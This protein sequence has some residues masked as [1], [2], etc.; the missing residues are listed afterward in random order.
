MTFSDAF[1]PVPILASPFDLHRFKNITYMKNLEE[2]MFG[3]LARQEITLGK[4]FFFFVCVCVI[5]G[6]D[7]FMENSGGYNFRAIT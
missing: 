7:H 4:P 1:L 2:F 3:S 5:D 6:I